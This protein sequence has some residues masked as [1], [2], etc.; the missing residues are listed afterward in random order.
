M[1]EIKGIGIHLVDEQWTVPT[2]MSIAVRG[3]ATL[4]VQPVRLIQ[5]HDYL[6]LSEVLQTA[7]S[8]DRKIIS[9]QEFNSRPRG[10]S[11]EATVLG[12]DNDRDFERKARFFSIVRM[13]G[14]L[15]IE[16]WP[17]AKGGGFVAN[18]PVWA[19]SFG[20]DEFDE[21][22]KFLIEKVAPREE[23]NLAD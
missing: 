13:P 12:F 3:G 20:Q 14:R 7:F 15:M 19:E 21:A 8:E 2:F 6:T 1:D 16:E 22:A 11:A 23:I 17:K 5:S 18:P 10:P 4:A 9:E